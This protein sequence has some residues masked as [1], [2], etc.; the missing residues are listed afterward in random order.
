MQMPYFLLL[1]LIIH[2]ILQRQ[3]F[4]RFIREIGPNKGIFTG[5]DKIFLFINTVF[6]DALEKACIDNGLLNALSDLDKIERIP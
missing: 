4:I 2:I 6:S 5:T 1:L 3:L